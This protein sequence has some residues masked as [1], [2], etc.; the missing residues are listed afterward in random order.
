[1][2]NSGQHISRKI[3]ADIQNNI[4]KLIQGFEDVPQEDRLENP[5]MF[6]LEKNK[7]R[8]NWIKWCSR[9]DG[10]ELVFPESERSRNGLRLQLPRFN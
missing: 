4:T 7:Q 2:Y 3:W 1:M 6:R 8:D 10:Q 9:E 5:G